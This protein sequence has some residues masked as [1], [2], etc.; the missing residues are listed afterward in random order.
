MSQPQV[1]RGD[2]SG[3]YGL[4]WCTGFPVQSGIRECMGKWSPVSGAVVAKGGI[5]ITKTGL[6][7]RKR[8]LKANE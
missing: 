5:V 3:S 1:E 2:R 7:R 6:E 4:E 8:N